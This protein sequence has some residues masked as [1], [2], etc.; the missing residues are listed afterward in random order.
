MEVSGVVFN[1]KDLVKRQHLASSQAKKL[2][3]GAMLLN[4]QAGSSK[5]M[6]KWL[7]KLSAEELLASTTWVGSV[8]REILSCGSEGE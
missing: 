7:D 5:T 2:E 4:T 3:E 8:F 1:S 6:Y